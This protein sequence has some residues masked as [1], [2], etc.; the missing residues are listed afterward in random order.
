MSTADLLVSIYERLLRAFGPQ[1]WWPGETPFE[2]CIGAI[3]T[4]NT[5]WSNVEKAISNLKARGVF[6]PDS[7]LG[8]SQAELAALIRPAGYFNQKARKIRDFLSW[9]V[10]TGGFEAMEGMETSALR[11]SLLSIRGI[12]P[13]TADSI[14][15]YALGRPIFVVDAYTVRA[16]SR[17]E[18]IAPDAD[19]REVQAL[20]H[21]NLPPDARMFN[22]F[23]ALFVRL[24]KTNCRKT[25]PLCDDCPLGTLP[26]Y[27]PVV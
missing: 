11:K 17:H 16:L 20:F 5:A 24:G 10:K 23:H 18:I 7:L 19:Y 25:G 13:E 1:G 3:L 9:F 6:D 4:Q 21:E 27:P 14:L 26:G 2:V 12:G 15:L 22:E 8:M